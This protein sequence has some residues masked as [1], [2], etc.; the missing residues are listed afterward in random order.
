MSNTSNALQLDHPVT[1]EVSIAHF[2]VV[3]FSGMLLSFV[4]TLRVAK[5]LQKIVASGRHATTKGAT[6]HSRTM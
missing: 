3:G 1:F 2:V 4:T 6:S 5:L